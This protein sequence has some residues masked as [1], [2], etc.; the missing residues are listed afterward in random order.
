MAKLDAIVDFHDP[1]IVLPPADADRQQAAKQGEDEEEPPEE[2]LQPENTGKA[3]K[4]KS[5]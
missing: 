5:D 2:T 4:K 1:K 3:V